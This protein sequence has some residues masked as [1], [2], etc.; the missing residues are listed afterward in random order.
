MDSSFYDERQKAKDRDGC[1]QLCG[2]T[3]QKELM[4]IHHTLFPANR[5][6]KRKRKKGN[7]KKERW[8]VPLKK[9]A[10]RDKAE[11][12]ILL[13][14]FCHQWFHKFF[15]DED[16]PVNYGK[17]K[18]FCRLCGREDFTQYLKLVD[19]SVPHSN[20]KISLC[21]VCEDA[22]LNHNPKLRGGGWYA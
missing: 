20:Q 2:A 5:Y 18:M 8:L 15:D 14:D 22:C 3:W 16:I 4:T 21:E 11:F 6:E 10:R 1:C 17:G 9:I 13:C 19:Y 12:L 7:R